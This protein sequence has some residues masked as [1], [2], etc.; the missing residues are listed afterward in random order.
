MCPMVIAEKSVGITLEVLDDLK[1][2]VLKQGFSSIAEEIKFFKETKPQFICKLIYFHKIFKIESK[3]PFG[4]CDFIKEYYKNEL[5]KLKLFSDKEVEF[6]R[7]YRT[8]STHLDMN[9]FVRGKF[10]IR[11]TLDS[12]NFESDP[13]FTTAHSYKI[14]QIKAYNHLQE[15]LED[16]LAALSG[17]YQLNKSEPKQK[18]VL[19][20]TSSKVALIELMYALHSEGVFNYGVSD[21]K[22]LAKYFEE[23]FNINL[24]Q[25]HRTFMEIKIRKTDRTKFINKLKQSMAKKMEDADK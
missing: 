19:T 17:L 23:A 24:G 8:G 20:W 6:Y 18:F 7:Y 21:L 9:Y 12:F 15:Y 11:L 2:E 16:R 14:A 5:Y 22:D 3:K 4:G 10:D 13:S 25:Y 1:N